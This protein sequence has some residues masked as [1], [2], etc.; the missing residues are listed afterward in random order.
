MLV[1][2]PNGLTSEDCGREI[3]SWV[4]VVVTRAAVFPKAGNKAEIQILSFIK[5]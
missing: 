4:A 2:S 1:F 3:I 5:S